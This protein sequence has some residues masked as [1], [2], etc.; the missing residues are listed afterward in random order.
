MKIKW[1]LPNKTNYLFNIKI[2]L[3]ILKKLEKLSDFSSSPKLAVLLFP[4][5][6]KVSFKTSI[7]AHCQ[8]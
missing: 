3:N 4:F 6:L 2:H 8:A 5:S 7:K 1:K